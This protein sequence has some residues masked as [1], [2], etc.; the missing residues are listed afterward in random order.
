MQ[1]SQ[2]RV[3]VQMIKSELAYSLS[4]QDR[5]TLQLVSPANQRQQ[6]SGRVKGHG[7]A[8]MFMEIVC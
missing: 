7:F 8:C 1:D 5:P 3:I 2:E 6:S 4:E